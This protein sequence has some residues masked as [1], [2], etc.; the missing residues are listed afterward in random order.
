M[1]FT[2]VFPILFFLFAPPVFIGLVSTAKKLIIREFRRKMRIK[3]PV[4]QAKPSFMKQSKEAILFLLKIDKRKTFN[5]DNK[6]II[7]LIYSIG[8][9]FTVFII[10]TGSILFYILAFLMPFITGAVAIQLYKPIYQARIKFYE[11]LLSYKSGKMKLVQK[12]NKDQATN[13]DEE[14]KIVEWEDNNIFPKKLIIYLPTSFSPLQTEGFLEEFQPLFGKGSNWVPDRS[15]PADP[16][17]NFDEGR[18]TLVH[19]PP[20]PTK[21]MWSE[22]Y[23]LNDSIAWSFFPLGLGSENG[24]KLKNENGEEEFVIGFDL[25]G[26]QSKLG[27]KKGIQ[28]GEEVIMAPQVLI[29]GGTGG[30]KA[31]SSDTIIPTVKADE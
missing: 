16:G 20:L 27:K 12:Q 7:M 18:V 9:V 26:E 10:L 28:V 24:V 1:F 25:A 2:I 14:F 8:I 4:V 5:L 31:L 30:G 11:K 29:A 23:L 3:A 22:H 6:I 17:W 21:A 19:T 13:Y 15:D